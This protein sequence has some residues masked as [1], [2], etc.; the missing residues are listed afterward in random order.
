MMHPL[1]P[2]LHGVTNAGI[3][4]WRQQLKQLL[5]IER[6]YKSDW[7]GESLYFNCEMHEG[8]IT[9]GM[10]NKSLEWHFAIFH[11]YNSFLLLAEEHRPAP[12]SRK[13]CIQNAVQRY[14]A[15][16]VVEWF[17]SLPFKV[18]PYKIERL[19]E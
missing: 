14:G 5:A 9:R 13:W 10:A 15:D 8:I 3:Y 6:G 16:N 1:D 17:Y 12:P 18:F 2:R 11:P 19:I 4:E 7:S